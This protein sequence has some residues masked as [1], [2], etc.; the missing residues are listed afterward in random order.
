PS[1][2]EGAG[3]YGSKLLPEV[4]LFGSKIAMMHCSNADRAYCPHEI[5]RG[6]RAERLFRLL[7]AAS[8]LVRAGVKSSVGAVHVPL[9][10]ARAPVRER[11]LEDARRFIIQLGLARRHERLTLCGPL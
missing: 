5:Q 6:S 3:A 2:A 4:S 1:P 9:R 10:V 8:P 11:H 7:M